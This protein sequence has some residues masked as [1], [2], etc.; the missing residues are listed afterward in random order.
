MTAHSFLT[1]EIRAQAEALR[2]AIQNHNYRY[3]VLDDPEVSDAE[4]DRLFAELKNL[5]EQYP[6]LRDVNSPTMRVGGEPATGFQQVRHTLPMYSL[7]NGFSVEDWEAFESR[8]RK[9]ADPERLTYWVDPK[10]DGL[11]VEV[12]YEKGALRLA[13]TR[14]DGIIGEDVTANM[15]TVR[16]LPLMLQNIPEMPDL[17]EVRGE[18]VM[19][20]KEFQALNETQAENGQKVFANPRNAAAGSLRQLDPGITAKRPLQ[21]LAYG[22]GQVRW[23]DGKARWSSQEEIVLGLQRLGFAV[24]P[25]A[26]VC[27]SP[28]TVMAVFSELDSKRHQLPFDIDGIVVKVNDRELQKQIG[29]TARA[30]RWALA[31]KFKAYQATT[32]LLE[33]SIQVGRTGVLTPVAKLAPVNLAG[34]TV[35]RATL[36]N[37]NEVR[38]KDL[39]IG[40]QVLIQRAGDVIPEVLRSLPEK[41]TGQEH[42]F[43]FPRH[44]P[45][46]GSPVTR[47]PEEVAWR[48]V[49]ASCSAKLTQGLIYF[50]SK[51]GLDVEGL[52][53]KWVDILV[54]QG[55]VN[56]AADLF[57]LKFEDLVSLDRMGEKSASNL[58]EAIAKAKKE[59]KLD[60]LINA[61]GIRH[62]G[63]QTSRVLAKRFQNLDELAKAGKET[64]ETLP[65]IGPEVS[66]SIEGFF[67]TPA[68]RALLA[69]FKQ[70]GLWPER[71]ELDSTAK[72]DSPFQGKKIVFTGKIGFPR[73]HAEKWVIEA[74]GEPVATVSKKVDVVVAGEEA[75]SKLN[76][77]RNLN[78]E[79]IS[80]DQFI[81]R[82]VQAGIDVSNNSRRE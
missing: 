66:A 54:Q 72:M 23:A 67:R 53:R 15:R 50:V 70:L 73:S 35:S 82:L 28:E 45:V 78:I 48:C 42:E 81:E 19:A 21:F 63:E 58:M 20:L 80:E 29:F 1:P 8:L 52:G 49:N 16:N 14:G 24:P 65:D 55:L 10:L 61:L 7:D 13:G 30:P 31:W 79:V 3:Y 9:L 41:R 18:V 26:R 11:A 46:C 64:L 39:R 27:R 76:K 22:I 44:C 57:R 40:D 68:N 5:E 17:L 43:Q 2:Q 12:V 37:E 51:A 6:G 25:L 62:V 33:I 38:A 59:A 34:V 47:L 32:K 4:Y 74:G 36:H 75:G 77:A 60:R 71:E 69:D 56:S